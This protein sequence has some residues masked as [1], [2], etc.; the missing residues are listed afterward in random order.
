MPWCLKDL[1]CNT[2]SFFW[3]EVF[4]MMIWPIL[5]PMRVWNQYSVKTIYEHLSLWLK[6]V[7]TCVAHL[8]SQQEETKIFHFHLW[9]QI[10]HEDEEHM[11]S[12]SFQPPQWLFQLS[13]HH[14]PKDK[15]IFLDKFLEI[16][17]LPEYHLEYCFASNAKV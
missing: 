16:L 15:N 17:S 14:P 5:I 2:V 3:V 6:I 7:A 11:L 9:T 13:M 4:M 10:Q 12:L 1:F 8:P